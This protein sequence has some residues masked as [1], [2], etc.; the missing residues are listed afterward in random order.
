VQHKV[1][2]GPIYEVNLEYFPNHSFKELAGQMPRL[3]NLGI[4]IIYLLPIWDCLGYQQ[5]LIADYDRISSRYGTAAE[6]DQIANVFQAKV[7][8]APVIRQNEIILPVAKSPQE[9]MLGARR[10]GW[11]DD[12]GYRARKE[13]WWLNTAAGTLH[14]VYLGDNFTLKVIGH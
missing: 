13:G 12:A 7:E 6:A 9:V 8:H 14:V 1:E 3:Q 4:K 5:Y 2:L 10:L 11:L